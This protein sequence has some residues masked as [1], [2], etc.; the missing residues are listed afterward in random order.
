MRKLRL[1]VIATLVLNLAVVAYA[2]TYSVL[3]ESGGQGIIAQGRDGNLYSTNDLGEAFTITPD[4]TLT[5]LTAGASGGLALGADGH[6]YGVSFRGGPASYGT[7][8]KMGPDGKITVLHNFAGGSDGLNPALPP[9]QGDDGNWYGVTSGVNGSGGTLYRMMPSGVLTT[10]YSFQNPNPAGQIPTSPLVQG[11]DGSLYGVTGSGGKVGYGTIFKISPT[12]ALTVLFNM[13][14]AY[15]I[16]VSSPLV[17]GSDGYF[18]G[19]ASNVCCY[20]PYAGTLFRVSSTGDFEVFYDFHGKSDGANPLGLIQATDGNFYGTTAE[21]GTGSEGTIFKFSPLDGL[22]VLHNFH[23]KAG[24][25]PSVGLI[26]HTNGMLYGDT[27]GGGTN[28]EG[29]FYR[30]DLGLP[31][32]VKLLPYSGKVGQVIEFLGQGF[33][34]T[35]TV[36]FNGTLAA[37]KVEQGT[38]LTAI[39]PHEATTGFV[40]VTTSQGTLTSDKIFRVTPQIMS[41]NPPSG[42]VGTKVTIAGVSLKQTTGVSFGGV[43]AVHVKIDSGREV[44]A[45]VPSGAKTGK[46]DIT[47]PGGLASSATGFTVT[48]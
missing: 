12:G 21:G 5:V 32:F 28:N 26:Q 9:V 40:T 22:S 6:F 3:H 18:Y 34:S 46:I 29:V 17:Q 41:F 35:T 14:G 10:L 20:P 11:T 4:G 16:N 15:G 37:S 45:V 8:F 27:V 47:T 19:T 31:P 23:K 43:T 24:T 30:L 42:P 33:T 36:S 2:Q 39:V 1:V 48:E 13:R 44:T 38:Y 7:V 25:N